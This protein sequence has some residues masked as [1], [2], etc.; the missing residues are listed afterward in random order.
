MK[1]KN[2]HDIET[3]S[4]SDRANLVMNFLIIFAKKTSR[5]DRNGLP[6]DLNAITEGRVEKRELEEWGVYFRNI[7]QKYLYNRVYYGCLIREFTRHI[8][9]EWADNKV[10]DSLV[11]YVLEILKDTFEEKKDFIFEEA[12]DLWVVI[13]YIKCIIISMNYEKYYEELKLRIF[14]FFDILNNN[15]MNIAIEVLSCLQEKNKLKKA[16]INPKSEKRMEIK[17]RGFFE[18]SVKNQPEGNIARETL[19]HLI[20]NSIDELETK[21]MIDV[22]IASLIRRL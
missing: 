20:K 17:V 7:E 13:K 2:I 5:I 4:G 12:E 1:G 6:M 9:G 22:Y 10:S 19:R 18:L 8:E 15:Q 14:E 3:K 16:D 21:K 11:C